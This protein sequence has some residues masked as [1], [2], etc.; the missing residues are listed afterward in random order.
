MFRL[1]IL[2]KM[3][4]IKI[5]DWVE[6]YVFDE[7]FPPMRLEGQVK[8]MISYGRS[9]IVERYIIKHNGEDKVVDAYNVII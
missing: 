6:F 9:E 1:C 7:I 3:K 5:G 8:E 2:I 4:T